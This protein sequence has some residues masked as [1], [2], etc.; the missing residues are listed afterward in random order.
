MNDLL[1]SLLATWLATNA[2]T[3]T[4]NLAVARHT[5]VA[6]AAM[7][8][9][10]PIEKEFQQIMAADDEAQADVDR[11]LRGKETSAKPDTDFTDLTRRAY[12]E[13]RL[14]PIRKAYEAFIARHPTHARARLAFGSFLNDTQQDGEAMIQW[15]KARELDPNN[16]AAWNNLAYYYSHSGPVTKAFE[17]L[18]K[19]IE[20]DPFEPVYYQN[21]ATVVFLFRT[22]AKERYRLPDDQRV[23]RRAID[24]Y[25]RARK[26]DPNNFALAT[27]VAQ[28]YYYL[29]VPPAADGEATPKGID[30]LANECLA[31]WDEALRIARTDLDRQGV[32]LHIARV[33]IQYQRHQDAR[34]HLAA[35]AAPA[36]AEL[37]RR[38]ARNLE[39]KLAGQPSAEE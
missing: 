28:V 19:A 38:V 26:L 33:C 9:N 25:L 23:F 11:W 7:D 30:D 3:T 16:P 15:E 21:L 13:Q 1:A 5:G 10:D 12:L 34:K 6:S 32:H 27:E 14:Q 37:K 17:Y 20:L 24:L 22:E 35:V 36:L 39:A 2:I 31:A 29:K 18:D 8:P 4:S